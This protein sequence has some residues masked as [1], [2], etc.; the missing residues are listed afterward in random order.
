MLAVE[1]PPQLPASARAMGQS[2]K[3]PPDARIHRTR[4]RCRGTGPHVEAR[5][6]VRGSTVR[7]PD[8]RVRDLPGVRA[9][10]SDLDGGCRRNAGVVA[11]C[12]P[13]SPPAWP[14]RDTPS[15]ARP[16]TPHLTIARVKDARGPSARAARDV[17]RRARRARRLRP[18]GRGHTVPES[19]VGGRIGL[20]PPI[21]DTIA[22]V[23]AILLGYLAGSVPF[24]FLLARRRGV[25]VRVAGSGNVGAANVMR[26]TGTGRAVAVMALDVAKGAAAV[27]LAHMSSGG[28]PLAA[29]TGAAAVVGHIYPVW[30][31]FHGGKGVAVA[32]GVFSVLAP[33]AT[34]VA[35]GLFVRNRLVD[36]LR[37]PRIDCGHD[38]AAA[39]GVAGRRAGCGRGGRRG[40]GGPDP[41]PSS[42]QSSAAP[43]RHRAPDVRRVRPGS[44]RPTSDLGLTVTELPWRR[45]TRGRAERIAI[46][47][48]GSWGTALAVHLRRTGHDVRLWAR[49][50]DAGAKASAR[51]GSI[52]DT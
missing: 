36:A 23:I 34:G 9:V 27:A 37:V 19:P 49:D 1:P 26:T 33:I 8:R 46:L 32:A 50:R 43:S 31:R 39:G 15:E 52:R 12:T 38:R 14:E 18:G 35:A 10:A 4:R 42:R 28:A 2:R 20:R 45:M 22:E 47:G 17:A 41:V 6:A 16:Y 11:C 13:R 21:A 7:A 5:A 30:L 25:D 3:P 40:D 29:V 24:A 51:T 48:A 44:W